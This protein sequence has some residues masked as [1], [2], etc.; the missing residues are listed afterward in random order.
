MIDPRLPSGY[1][2]DRVNDLLVSTHPLQDDLFLAFDWHDTPQGDRYWRHIHLQARE[3]SDYSLPKPAVIYLS[4]ME[5]L[6]A[7]QSSAEQL[8]AQPVPSKSIL[9]ADHLESKP[10]TYLREILVAVNYDYD[11]AVE[12]IVSHSIHLDH[13][14]VHL[15]LKKHISMLRSSLR[16]E[17][18][19]W[20][21]GKGRSL[22]TGPAIVDCWLSYHPDGYWRLSE[23]SIASDRVLIDSKIPARLA[24]HL[25]LASDLMTVSQDQQ[26]LCLHSLI[27]GK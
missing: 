19:S 4:Q 12:R 18:R 7:Q 21:N 13:D 27:L 17:V 11:Q 20:F 15:H 23:R 9:L 8:A 26:T 3:T 14:E 25:I 10:D 2:A 5:L 1:A 16:D 22:E 24:Y 6:H